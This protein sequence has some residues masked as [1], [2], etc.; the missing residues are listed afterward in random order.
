MTREEFYKLTDILNSEVLGSFMHGGEADEL[1][2]M[3]EEAVEHS[4]ILEQEEPVKQSVDEAMAEIERKVKLFT[5]AN[6]SKTS[7][8]ILS[9][10]RGKEPVSDDLNEAAR[11]ITPKVLS[12]EAT[13]FY[14]DDDVVLS[15]EEEC[16][17]AGAQWQKSHLWKLADGDDLPEID[18]EV[19]VLVKYSTQ[20]NIHD[21]EYFTYRVGFGHRPNPDGWDGRNIDTGVVTHYTPKLYDKGG[22]NVPDIAYW[23]DV[24]L[25]KEI[26]L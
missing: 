3:F 21:K 15:D 17:K 26:E 8:E 18:R 12:G 5:E 2:A 25:P 1:I 16:F 23:L 22:W 24:E 19:I 6:K 14:N 11:Q 9:E 7:E 20:R 10:M 13:N 4:N